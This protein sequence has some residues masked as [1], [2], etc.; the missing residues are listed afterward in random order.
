MTLAA[1]P[2]GITVSGLASGTTTIQPTSFTTNGPVNGETITSLTTAILNSADVSANGCNYV[3]SIVGGGGTAMIN[4]YLI[5]QAYNATPNSDTT[6]TATINPRAPPI[7]V[8]PTAEPGVTQ[9]SAVTLNVGLMTPVAPSS[10]PLPVVPIL[11]ES[12]P[13]PL[14]NMMLEQELNSIASFERSK[15]SSDLEDNIKIGNANDLPCT[16]SRLLELEIS[17][18]RKIE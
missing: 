6:N 1:A 8:P 16:H 12:T 18:E 15:N 14:N 10:V 5:T 2:L 9:P 7:V 17:L 13:S 4:I 3:V 11:I